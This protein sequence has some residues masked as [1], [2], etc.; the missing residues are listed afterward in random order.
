MSS[1]FHVYLIIYLH[2]FFSHVPN[3]LYKGL[4]PHLLRL[5]MAKTNIIITAFLPLEVTSNYV[6]KK[7]VLFA[8]MQGRSG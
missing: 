3:D 5:G 2:I 6:I 4:C 1:N 8:Y 7:I